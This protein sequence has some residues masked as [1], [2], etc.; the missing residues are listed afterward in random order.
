METHL[1]QR[2][3]VVSLVNSVQVMK[4]VSMADLTGLQIRVRNLKL[5]S[6]FSTKIY[7]VGTQKNRLDGTQ[8]TCLN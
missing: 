4:L 2:Q 1:H 7:A 3:P 8:N 6:Y 5:F